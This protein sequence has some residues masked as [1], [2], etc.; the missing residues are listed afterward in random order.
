MALQSRLNAMGLCPEK[1]GFETMHD[2]FEVFHLA[3]GGVEV[4]GET[5]V[6]AT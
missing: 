2:G 4:E 3:Q 1:D 6:F 5:L